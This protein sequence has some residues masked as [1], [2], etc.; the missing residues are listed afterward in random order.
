MTETLT[1]F[2]PLDGWAAPL[3]EV[4]D[5]VFAERMLGDGVAVDPTGSVLCAPCDGTVLSVHHTGHAVSVRT[6]SGVEV[7]M[8][9]GLETVGLSGE[10][11]EVLVAGGQAI[12]A[13]DPL[14]RFDM[15]VIAR[16]A[17]SL[18]T[19]IIVTN[20][21]DF[22]VVSHAEGRPVRVGE[23]LMT[24]TRLGQ[25]AGGA[26]AEGGEARRQVA[27]THG[28][29]L[30]ARPAALLAN[31][32]KALGAVTH[33]EFG[34]RRASARSPVAVM[35]LGVRGGDTV[36]LT[37]MGE[38]AVDAVEAL[39]RVI[40]DQ[41][42]AMPAPVAAA[43]AAPAAPPPSAEIVP[44]TTLKGVRAAPGLAIGAAVRLDEPEIEVAQV[45]VGVAEE[46]QALDAAA[47]AVRMKLAAQAQTGSADQQA[48]LE[49]HL[50]FLEDPEL[51]D[52]AREAIGRGLSAGLAWREAVQAQVAV[53]EALGDAHL[54]ERAADLRDLERQVLLALSGESAA[55]RVL[56][57]NAIL[58]A[59]DLLPSQ[60]IGLDPARIAGI[61]LARGGPTSHVA[62]LASTLNIPA[63]VAAGPRVLAI[64][65][66]ALLILDGDA[67][68]LQV[69]PK[70][71]EIEAAQSRLAQ[72][73]ARRGAA[74]AVAHEAARTADGVR[75]EV[76]ANVAS[77]AEAHAAAAAGAEGCG[78]LR[79]EFLFLDR[80]TA[81][82]EDEQARDYQ[83]V[84][85]A[86]AG[87]TVIVRTLDAG[88]DKPLAYLPLPTEENPA[89]GLRGVRIGLWRPELLKTQ[90]RAIL[91]A[92]PEGQ[93]RIMLPMVASLSELRAARALAD[94]AA[95]ELGLKGRPQVGIMVET[96]AAA[97]TADLLAAEADF[98]SI[99]ANDLAQYALAMDRTNSDFAAQIDGMHPAVLRLIGQAAAG[100]AKHGRMVAVCG[101]LAFEPAAVP[102]LIGL[103]V[104]ELSGAASAVPEIKALVRSLTLPACRT[105]ADQAL[106]QTSAEAVRALSLPAGSASHVGAR[107]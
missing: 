41:I 82:D 2:S 1:L 19:P 65:D 48:I 24:L 49:A 51:V 52:A 99:G 58:L 40:E 6:G 69:A 92:S 54:A 10:G 42:N 77:V 67:G 93:C 81:P 11:F 107:P 89:L 70:P 9:I 31:A 55:E 101:A 86:L 66:G 74:Q 27:V 63:V 44:L 87:R 47:A 38:G 43:T 75:I 30:H 95:A 21:D 59:E 12:K 45:A 50:A 100:G 90:L 56:P 60:L 20:G 57:D 85:E 5:A 39:A 7:L 36:T 103:G 68:L 29:G 84:A 35:S 94:E 53:L 14:I 23:P 25:V 33:V 79:T 97:V 18:I 4:P 98:L 76:F 83:A 96:P 62:I 78:L 8:H 34:E 3:S 106:Q 80:Q 17:K 102:I 13:G 64:Q 104:T 71:A 91:R 88:G 72:A 61:C 15:D 37:A 73:R 32:A 26:A 22:L 105:L 46:T 28:H 16:R